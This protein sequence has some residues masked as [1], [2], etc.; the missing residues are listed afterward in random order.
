MS[1]VSRAPP[2]VYGIKPVEISPHTI[3]KVPV[4]KK[5]LEQTPCGM[6][7]ATGSALFIPQG[8]SKKTTKPFC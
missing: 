1:Y 4:K 8:H 2:G 7:N 5:M 6:A 3:G